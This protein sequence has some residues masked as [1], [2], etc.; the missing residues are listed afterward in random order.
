SRSA[1]CSRFMATC[2]S[3]IRLPLSRR[4]RHQRRGDLDVGHG[5]FLTLRTGRRANY[6]HAEWPMA[7]PLVAYTRP[8]PR[9]R[10]PDAR[11]YSLATEEVGSMPCLSRRYRVLV[12]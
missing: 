5:L 11:V 1:S 9:R 10:S 2:G 6:W 4:L 3:G 8:V 12:S 7:P